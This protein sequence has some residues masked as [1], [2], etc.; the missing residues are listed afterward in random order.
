M[1]I[2]LYVNWSVFLQN[3]LNVYIGLMENWLSQNGVVQ[4]SHKVP[5]LHKVS[6]LAEIV[7]PRVALIMY[8]DFNVIHFY[9]F[10]HLYTQNNLFQF[11]LCRVICTHCP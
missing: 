10:L 3:T 6:E 9:I 1:F 4:C 5:Q 7:N 11:Y 8:C 2:V